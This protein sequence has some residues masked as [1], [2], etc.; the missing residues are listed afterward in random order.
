MG[1]KRAEEGGAVIDVGAGTGGGLSAVAGT[2]PSQP[3]EPL[4]VIR[5]LGQQRGEGEERGLL[6][7]S[8]GEGAL[9]RRRNSIMEP[10]RNL[11]DRKQQ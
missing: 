5:G 9:R 6:R 2:Q 8:E 10:H 1:P 7:V 3:L 4:T 11:Q